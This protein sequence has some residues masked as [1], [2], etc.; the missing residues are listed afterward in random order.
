MKRQ[1]IIL[2]KFK[3]MWLQK[4]VYLFLAAGLITI[5]VFQSCGKKEE[6]QTF[7]PPGQDS[8]NREKERLAREEFERLKNLQNAIN[9]TT[10]RTDSLLALQDSLKTKSD[11]AKTKAPDKKKFVQK[12]KELNKRLDNPKTTITDY[13]EFLQR[14]TNEGGNFEQNM[15]RA[16][17]Q[18]QSSNINRFKTNYKN[19]TK[20]VVLEE[21]KVISQKGQEATVQVKIKKVDKVNG[22]TKETEMLV[23]YNLIADSKGKWK[24]KNN[25]V[26]MK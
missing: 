3:N 11:T 21:P 22:S 15:K 10:G 13:I 19:T 16:S 25:D 14:G 9:D 20:I 2:L 4:K 6:P 17:E 5:S 8:I 24:I 23:K 1:K 12:E 7:V 26:S 18:W